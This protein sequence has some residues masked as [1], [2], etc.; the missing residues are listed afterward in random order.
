MLQL[1]ETICYESGA[2]QRIPLHEERMKHSRQQLFGVS[3]LL[4][5]SR[6]SIPESLKDQKVKCRITYSL[7]IEDIA[8]EPYINKSIKSL[9]LVWEDAIDYSHKYKNRDSLNRLLGM[10]G[11]CDE[12]LVVKNGMIT[13]TSFSNIVFLKGGTWYT[14]EYPLLPGTR[15]EDYL[16]KNQ[17]FP[18]VIKPEDLGQYEEARLINS[19][20]SLD[21][22]DPIQISGIF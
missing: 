22:A 6:L 3:D 20:R 11:V 7:Q 13:D 8:Y 21:D 17:I 18:R 16:R 4:S 15:R 5:L 2:F 19:M 14:P 10:R 9:K 1:I 12:I